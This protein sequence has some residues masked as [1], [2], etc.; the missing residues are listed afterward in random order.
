MQVLGLGIGGAYVSMTGTSMATPHVSG[1]AALILAECVA[2]PKS[3]NLEPLILQSGPLNH[4]TD[5]I[6]SHLM[7]LS[8]LNPAT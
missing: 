5:C 4:V 3:C 1:T 6:F 2:S 7:R 8:S